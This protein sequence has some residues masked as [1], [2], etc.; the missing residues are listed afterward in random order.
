MNIN[1]QVEQRINAATES[2]GP[3]SGFTHNKPKKVTTI[4]LTQP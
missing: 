2:A 3:P 4:R 1:A